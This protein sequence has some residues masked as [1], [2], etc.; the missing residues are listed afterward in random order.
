VQFERPWFLL[1]LLALPGLVWLARRSRSGL[2]RGRSI[3]GT[4]LRTLLV[5]AVVFS[6]ADAHWTST[7]YR[8]CT[9]FLLDHSFSIPVERQREALDWINQQLGKRPKDDLAGVIVFGDQAMIELPPAD[10]T[11]LQGP[12]SI[13][14]RAA[15]DVG[16][17]VRLALAVFPRGY[18]KRIVLVSDGNENRGH[19]LAEAELARSQGAVVDVYPVGYS[20]A[21]EVWMEALHVPSEVLPSEPFDVTAVVNSQRDTD[22]ILTIFRNGE[23]ISRQPVR[24]QKGKNV[25]GVKQKVEGAGHF[26]YEAVVESPGD[27]VTMNNSSFA[28]SSARG[29]ARIAVVAGEPVDAEELV[30]ALREENL[31]PSVY[32]PADLAR[33]RFDPAGFDVIVFANV[34]ALQVGAAPMQAVEA[35]VHDAGVGFLMIGGERSYGPGGYRGTPV[36]ELLPVTMEQP[37]RRVIPNGALALILHTCEFPDGNYWA[38]Q[39]ALAA[40]N[41]LGPRDLMGVLDYGAMGE[42]WIFPMT[43]AADKAKLTRL[44]LAAEPGDMPSFDTT[45]E[46]AHKG[47]QGVQA[48][49]KHLVII[50]DSDPSGPSVGLVDAMVKDRITISTVAIYPHSGTDIDKMAAVAA[51]A[52]GRFYHVQDP[53]RLPQIF[54]KEAATLQ[55]SMIIEGTIPPMVLGRTDA[56]TGIAQDEIPPLRGYTLTHKKDLARVALGAPVSKADALEGGDAPPDV[57]LAE[58][59]YGLGRTMAFTSDAKN[60]WGRDWV[61]WPK[62]KKF[63]AQAVRSVTRTVP[64][65]P[66][67]VQTEIEGGKGKVI[68]DAIDEQGRFVH[69]LQFQGSVTSPD[70]QKSGLAFRQV[71]PGRY[72]AEFEAGAVGVY[73]VTGHYQGAHGEKGYLSQGVPLSYAAEY[74]DLKANLSLLDQVRARTDGRRLEKDTPLYERLPHSAG[75]AMPLWPWLLMGVLALLPVDIFIRRVAID[76]G[77]AFR[78]LLLRKKAEAKAAPAPAA[79]LQLQKAKEAVSLPVSNVEVDLTASRTERAAQPAPRPPSAETP[80]EKEAGAYLDRLL[81]AK[82]KSKRK[83]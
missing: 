43:L 83:E 45:M 15:T 4:A 36:E 9:I 74:R 60:R 63:W 79:I 32:S 54:I 59:I 46:M 7:S 52:K 56:L 64:R 73:S 41:V 13:V 76:W 29:D 62:Y 77:A 22:G 3:V 6:L 72:E 1:L 78:K 23:P 8:T 80:K 24:L 66:F 19:A 40:L 25:F 70:G 37:Q 17:A 5:S 34:E 47:L 58:W 51:R 10:N 82:K 12:Y 38:K 20:H 53:K 69:T 28:F 18:Q 50:S 57:L 42:E 11:L 75:I 81:E 39:I 65:A 14:G 55:R 16:A 26:A 35:A 44:I 31:H 67:G 61:G 27:T 48:A 33:A 49:S 2:E 21:N 30:K 68:V 71:G